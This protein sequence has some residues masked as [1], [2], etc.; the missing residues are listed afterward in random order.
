MRNAQYS[1]ARQLKEIQERDSSNSGNLD[2]RVAV[3][4]VFWGTFLESLNSAIK[5]QFQALFEIGSANPEYANPNP[6]QWAEGLIRTYIH[7]SISHTADFDFIPD[8]GAPIRGVLDTTI[9]P[10]VAQQEDYVEGDVAP[11]VAILTDFWVEINNQLG[12][13]VREAEVELARRGW[14][15]LETKPTTIT[16]PLPKAESGPQTDLSSTSQQTPNATSPT[17]RYAWYR[18]PAAGV[19]M[20]SVPPN[21][22]PFPVADSVGLGYI[23]VAL[24]AHPKE[25]TPSQIKALAGANVGVGLSFAEP[26]QL[27]GSR[28]DGDGARDGRRNDGFSSYET[29][30]DT[31]DKKAVLK[32]KQELEY[33]ERELAK[34][35]RHQDLAQIHFWNDKKE[36]L[37]KRV[38]KDTGLNKRPRP[39]PSDET[40]AYGTVRR[41]IARVIETISKIDPDTGRFLRDNI[42]TG[43]KV[44]YTGPKVEWQ[45]YKK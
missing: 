26:P 34:A 8:I 12:Q 38:R 40:R 3:S 13:L 6:A 44:S 7:H 37:L 5:E 36:K 31:Y 2:Y 22:K 42:R 9:L 1:C 41:G 30:Q 35:S 18:D 28:D 21:H 24:Q 39:M 27:D 17:V 14:K 15:P 25:L 45:F 20:I 23:H 11:E 43:F 10:A 29:P 32:I 16:S 33:I 4:E 19:W